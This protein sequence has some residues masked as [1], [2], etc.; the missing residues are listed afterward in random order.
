ML[1]LFEFLACGCFGFFVF[2]DLRRRPARVFDFL[3]S[4]F[5]ETVRGDRQRF[6][7]VAGA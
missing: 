5:R 3:F 2:E 1:S 4:G 7:N 6:G